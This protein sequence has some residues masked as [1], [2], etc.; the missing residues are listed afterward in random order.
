MPVFDAEAK[1]LQEVFTD[2]NPGFRIPEYQRTYDWG[3][4]NIERLFDDVLS[5]V[6][7]FLVDQ[8]TLTFL[9]TV[10]VVEEGQSQQENTFSSNSYS[11]VDGQQRLTTVALM[12][13]Q[14]H[15]FLAALTSGLD[16]LP[17]D[18][19]RWLKQEASSTQG[20]LLN[21]VVGR[22]EVDGGVDNYPFPRIVRDQDIRGN[23][24]H[25][26]EYQTYV[27]KYLMGYRKS[28]E[29]NTPEFTNPTFD[30]GNGEV[31]RFLDNVECI[32]IF[33][34]SVVGSEEALETDPIDASECGRPG[35]R[36]IYNHLPSDEP[37]ANAIIDRAIGEYAEKTIE[38]LRL[39][40][41][42]RYLLGQVVITKV[43]TT[44]AG[45][46]F[47][48]FDALNTTGEPL[49]AIE[50][51]KPRI[52][53][54]E[55][56]TP[57]GRTYRGSESEQNM[58]IVESFLGSFSNPQERQNQARDLVISFALYLTADKCSRHLNSQ[59]RYMQSQ[60]AQLGGDPGSS[61]QFTRNLADVA[62][63]R[64][65]FWVSNNLTGELTDMGVDRSLVLMCLSYL[66][67]LKNSLSF[68]IL[69]RYYVEADRQQNWQLF[70]DAVKAVTAY[71]VIRRSAT[72]GTAGID[73]DLRKIMEQGSR[74]PGGV[75][76]K[77]GVE[78]NGTPPSIEQ[79][80]GYLRD[81]L[82]IRKLQISDRESWKQKARTNAVYG[83]SS[84]ITCKFLMHAA[85]HNANPSAEEPKLMDK[86]RP[87]PNNHYLDHTRWNS[88][89]VETIEHI[90]P[91]N[92]PERNWDDAIY[93]TPHL[94]DSLGNLTLLPKEQNSAVGNTSW[95]KKRLFYKAF[96]A[97]QNEDVEAQIA[98]AA[99][100]GISFGPSTIDMLRDMHMLPISKTVAAHD[101]WDAN[102]IEQRTSNILDLAWHEVSPWLRF[103]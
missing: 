49:T 81:W 101:T 102:V 61:R 46:A 18:I 1:P 88:P 29:P 20:R 11:I 82:T 17:E 38:I 79:L 71:V 58:E 75:P 74:S 47:D 37:T 40:L 56:E 93:Q 96:A 72:S 23:S 28:L 68:P 76:L 55:R 52:T 65:R 34:S 84:R 4:E 32:K 73:S 12:A 50:T 69:C 14:S 9:G 25:D 80:C 26:A 95:E 6:K 44:S 63:F 59:R 16:D 53:S 13:L 67:Q 19:T 36:S 86:E 94:V 27:A 99:E 60:F 33:M 70:A 78:S 62:A 39:I 54:F 51:F 85:A 21:C 8:E 87:S 2:K 57:P 98:R 31:E 64:N 103:N 35:A 92:D 3:K 10:I 90:A 24:P 41:F 42:A 100:N 89:E 91:Q 66:K 43:E 5:G 30:P 97:E 77:I 7:T 45:Y 83:P 15:Q 48:I 22:L